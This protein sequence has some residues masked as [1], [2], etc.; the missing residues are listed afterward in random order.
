MLVTDPETGKSRCFAIA[1]FRDQMRG[2]LVIETLNGKSL[3][4][5]PLVVNEAVKKRKGLPPKKEP[6]RGRGGPGAGGGGGGGRFPNRGGTGRS[7]SRPF[8]RGNSNRDYGGS[9]GG[10]GG[11]GPLGPGSLRAGGSSGFSRSQPLRPQQPWRSGDAVPRR[12][13]PPAGGPSATPRPSFQRPFGASSSRPPMGSGGGSVPNRPSS[14]A[15]G[16]GRAPSMPPSPPRAPSVPPSPPRAPSVP[17]SPPVRSTEGD[18]N[19]GADA[20][21]PRQP[22]PATRRPSSRPPSIRRTDSGGSSPSAQD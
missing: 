22:A 17:P 12:D 6:G 16:P 4:G 3:L 1:M 14:P 19:S 15:S 13:V 10:S 8:G 11:R 21:P 18:A 2:Q 7:S 9:G 20:K 5:R